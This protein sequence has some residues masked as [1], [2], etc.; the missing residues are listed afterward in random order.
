MG[1]GN[2]SEQ[3]QRPAKSFLTLGTHDYNNLKQI[4]PSEN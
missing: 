3:A 2:Q 4:T 1:E